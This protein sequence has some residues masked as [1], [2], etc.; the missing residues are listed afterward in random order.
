LFAS[1]TSESAGIFDRRTTDGSILTFRKDGAPVGS[2]GVAGD[3]LIIGST[4]VG[5]LFNS[6]ANEILPA[7]T[8]DTSDATKSLGKSTARFKDLY[9]S[10][11][12]NNSTGIVSIG[13]AQASGI[14]VMTTTASAQ[15]RLRPAADNTVDLG[16]PSRRFQDIYLSGGVV[17]GTGGPSP[18]TSNTLD[19]YE[20]GTWTPI[21]YTESGTSYTLGTPLVCRYIKIGNL[22]HVEAHIPFTVEG[23]GSVTMISLPFAASGYTEM[24]NGYVQSGVN[25][26]SFK[27]IHYSGSL[28]LVSYDSDASY[29]NYWAPR[30]LWLPNDIFRFSGAYHV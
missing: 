15:P 26:R 25:H 20:E 22:V 29:S 7:T 3:N 21:V 1:R 2:I 11:G 4:D 14:E 24:F 17:F 19:D 13:N 6:G 8:T 23:S 28:V 18:I 27:F 16:Q 9:L 30:S 10:G 5:L 12:V